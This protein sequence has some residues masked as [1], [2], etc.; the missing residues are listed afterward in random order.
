MYPQPASELLRNIGLPDP[1]FDLALDYSGAEETSYE[2]E[3]L[4]RS[5]L[6]YCAESACSKELD[7]SKWVTKLTLSVHAS[8]I[9]P[10]AGSHSVMGRD[11]SR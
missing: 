8:L 7:G 11:G 3:T 9:M 4:G 5:C 6:G 1:R 2:V 10:C